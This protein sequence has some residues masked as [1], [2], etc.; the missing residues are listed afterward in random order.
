[1]KLRVPA[2]VPPDKAEDAQPVEIELHLGEE[3][4]DAYFLWACAEPQPSI[5]SEI[6]WTAWDI[7]WAVWWALG[8]PTVDFL[9]I[10]FIAADI[11]VLE[12]Q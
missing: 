11:E 6:E 12:D 3:E 1:M 2:Y 8:R 7:R 10:G 5:T 4:F 9:D